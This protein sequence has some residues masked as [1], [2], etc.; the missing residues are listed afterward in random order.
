MGTNQ[1]K[2]RAGGQLT[3]FEIVGAG[4]DGG[5][6]ATDDRVIWVQAESVDLIHQAIEGTGAQLSDTIAG[7]VDVDFRIPADMERL[8]ERLCSFAVPAPV[9]M[10]L[11]MVVLCRNSEGAPEF[12]TCAVDVTAAQCASGD[13]YQ[14]AEDN[15]AYNGYEPQFSF[16]QDDPAAKQLGDILAW[17]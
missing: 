14:L 10:N 11:K 12:H 16:C 17:L 8:R 15:A 7:N 3:T 9:T 4:Y 2:E 5:T 13:H 1:G 6:D